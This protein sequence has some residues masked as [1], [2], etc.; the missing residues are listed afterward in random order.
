MQNF[1]QLPKNSHQLAILNFYPVIPWAIT[2]IKINQEHCCWDNPATFNP[3]NAKLN[4][5][6]HLLTML[7]AYFILH[8][9]RI[10]VNLQNVLVNPGYHK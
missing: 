3:L 6:C 2:K 1:D 4:P 9:S 5:I 10:K 8:V 7:E